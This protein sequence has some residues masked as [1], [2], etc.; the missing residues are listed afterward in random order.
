[1]LNYQGVYDMNTAVD[2]ETETEEQEAAGRRLNNIIL[3]LNIISAVGLIAV[4][5]THWLTGA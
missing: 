1:M 2:S 3:T 5:V 4:F